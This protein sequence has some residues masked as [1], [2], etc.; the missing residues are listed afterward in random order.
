MKNKKTIT[1]AELDEKFDNGEDI[2]E[3]LDLSSAKRP[4]REARRVNVDFP[5]W[6]VDAMDKEADRIGIT[7][8]AYIKVIVAERLNNPGRP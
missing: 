4:G 6:M 3:Y 7:R 5:S 8:Q 2:I 1:A